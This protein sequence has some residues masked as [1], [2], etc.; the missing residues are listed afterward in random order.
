MFQVKGREKLSPFEIAIN[1]KEQT[2]QSFFNIISKLSYLHEKC[3]K[4]SFD[5]LYEGGVLLIEKKCFD[6]H[7]EAIKSELR[8][9]LANSE[10]MLGVS[11]KKSLITILKEIN[12]VGDVQSDSIK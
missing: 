11:N 12:Y 10:D 6:K 9:L 1:K 5:H 8:S 3:T 4:E 2:Y 7:L